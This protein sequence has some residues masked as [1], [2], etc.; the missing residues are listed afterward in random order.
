MASLVKLL[1]IICCARFPLANGLGLR[2]KEKS[3]WL[4]RREK[5]PTF[6]AFHLFLLSI[7]GNSSDSLSQNSIAWANLL[8][9]HLS[10]SCRAT[11]L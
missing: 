1:S 11:Y 9:S 2:C 8:M 6:N 4:E 7:F 5:G 3:L 10:D